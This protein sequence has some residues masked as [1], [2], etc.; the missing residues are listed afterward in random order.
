MQNESALEYLIREIEEQRTVVVNSIL[1]GNISDY[2]YRRLV[3]VIQGLDFA[4]TT[5]NDLAKRLETD[6]DE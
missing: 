2:E 4:K 1:G 3:G 5:I 6:A